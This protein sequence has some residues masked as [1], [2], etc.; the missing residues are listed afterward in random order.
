MVVVLSMRFIRV[1]ISIYLGPCYLNGRALVCILIRL[2]IFFNAKPLLIFYV[3]GNFVLIV[4]TL[5]KDPTLLWRS[6][7]LALDLKPIT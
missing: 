5:C 3:Y 1:G 7:F 6:Y 4:Y 2:G